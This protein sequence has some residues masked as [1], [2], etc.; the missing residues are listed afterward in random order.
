MNREFIIDAFDA[1]ASQSGYAF[2][3]GPEEMIAVHTGRFPSLWL[4][5]PEVKNLSGT[6]ECR[7]E[8][9]L[10]FHLLSER[11]AS[12]TA[13]RETVWQHLEHRARELLPAICAHTPHI[14]HTF[15][16]SCEAGAKPLTR[17]AELYVTVRF[18]IEV[19]YL[20]KS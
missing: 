12:L 5:P 2:H 3:T 15:G 10:K 7:M 6:E 19:F 9:R 20:N 17:G 4:C 1:A 8:Y 13:D 16:Y 18:G 11:Q 14:T